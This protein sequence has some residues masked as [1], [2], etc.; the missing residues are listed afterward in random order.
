MDTTM[1]PLYSIVS[2]GKAMYGLTLL[3]TCQEELLCLPSALR[4]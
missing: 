1:Q 4:P 2:Q 3:S